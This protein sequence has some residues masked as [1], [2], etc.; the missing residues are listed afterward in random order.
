MEC[1]FVPRGR[2]RGHDAAGAS[3]PASGARSTAAY[4]SCHTTTP[5]GFD[6]QT[7]ATTRANRGA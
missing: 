7:G 1:L 2:R 6:L 5:N 4:K 3:T